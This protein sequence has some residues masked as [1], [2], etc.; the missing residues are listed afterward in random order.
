MS[1]KTHKRSRPK[2]TWH[3]DRV[4]FSG[5]HYQDAR[6]I[7]TLVQLFLY[8]SEERRKEKLKSLQTE[9][10]KA[11]NQDCAKE[12]RRMKFIIERLE[13]DIMEGIKS[14]FPPKPPETLSQQKQRRKE[15]VEESRF[16][17]KFIEDAI[18]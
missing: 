11:Y 8:S 15:E 10:E 12:N 14:T 5:L 18:G 3:N 4:T 16:I 1:K 7:C 13:Q 6:R 2:A 17:R 9:D